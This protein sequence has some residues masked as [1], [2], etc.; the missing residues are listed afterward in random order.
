VKSIFLCGL[1]VVVA[2]GCTGEYTP[3]PGEE[4]AGVD[5]GAV[6]DNADAAPP[7][8]T[9]NR[10]VDGLQLLYRFEGTAGQAEVADVSGVGE[11][12]NLTIL[13]PAAVTWEAEGGMTI[14]APTVVQNT[15]PVTK[16]IEACS[17]SNEITVELWL[18]N[19]TIDGEGD[20]GYV[21]TSSQAETANVRNFG[22]HQ[23]DDNWEF[24][25]RTNQ[26]GNNGANP[27][28]PAVAGTATTEIQHV[29][30]TRDA[31]SQ[32]ANFYIDTQKQVPR[33]IPGT[34]SN[35]GL[36]YGVYLANEPTVQRP[37]LGTLYLA[38]VYCRELS[39]AEI[40]Q[41]Y[42]EGY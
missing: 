16:A 1:S 36:D 5:A 21:F 32:T 39:A 26:T 23:D 6:G 24:H 7:V 25:L 9:D 27:A 40:Q 14:T 18:K 42:A 35:W 29:V 30:Y 34:L 22:I 41:N 4:N 3:T 28:A 15:G 8:E 12:F 38:A 11:P 31:L 33:Q 17:Q 10:V 2:A 37:W 20:Q 13:D 19:A